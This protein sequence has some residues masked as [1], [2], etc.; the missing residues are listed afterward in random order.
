MRKNEWSHCSNEYIAR[1][2]LNLE[3]LAT[4][5]RDSLVQLLE[6]MLYRWKPYIEDNGDTTSTDTESTD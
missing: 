3:Y 1:S 5:D 4:Q 6:E 2:V